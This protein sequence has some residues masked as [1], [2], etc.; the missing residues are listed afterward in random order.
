MGYR[1]QFSLPNYTIDDI[2]R[3]GAVEYGEYYKCSD[4][5]YY[6]FSLELERSGLNDEFFVDVEDMFADQFG[7]Y[8]IHMCVR[9]VELGDGELELV[10]DR[11]LIDIG[12][13]DFKR[14]RLTNYTNNLVSMAY[15]GLRK[16]AGFHKISSEID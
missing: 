3:S 11:F 7:V 9:V 2:F 16:L 12:N 4:E 6:W 5:N 1:M 15:E 13:G 8:A 10:D 14:V